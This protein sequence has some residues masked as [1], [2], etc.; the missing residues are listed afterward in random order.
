MIKLQ[1]EG[2]IEPNNTLLED[3]EMLKLVEDVH[4]MYVKKLE[5]T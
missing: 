3:I 1:N 5:I 4:H 2:Y